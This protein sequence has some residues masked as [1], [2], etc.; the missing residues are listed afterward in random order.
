MNKNI[1]YAVIMLLIG[2]SCSVNQKYT[3]R[4]PQPIITE[5][6]QLI[7]KNSLYFSDASIIGNGA[8]LIHSESSL[9][10][11]HKRIRETKGIIFDENTNTFRIE[12]SIL[13]DFNSYKV[14]E[15]AIIPLK[16]LADSFSNL[17]GATL[18]IYGHTDNIGSEEYNNAL[19]LK[20]A[21]AI[22][23]YLSDLGIPKER[24]ESFGLGEASP[25]SSNDSEQGRQKNRRVE[26]QLAQ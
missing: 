11:F 15:Q 2:A 12:Q 23:K 10:E 6:E 19:S 14:K 5:K 3:E 13:F 25:I 24:I 22:A 18:Q 16:T 17:D 26:F 9:D 1:S 20:R 4:S 7:D 21:Q 8:N